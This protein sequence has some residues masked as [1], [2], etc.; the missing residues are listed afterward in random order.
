MKKGVV[1]LFFLTTVF[2]R[3]PAFAQCHFIPSTTSAVDTVVYTF[4][5]GNFA[6]YGCAPIDPTYWLSGNGMSVTCT[7]V[8]PQDYPAIR[9]WGMNDD[10]SAEV[11]VNSVS[12]FLDTTGSA[13]YAP[14][15][16][17]GISPGPDGIIFVNGK[18]VGANSNGL[19]NYSY[20]DVT[21][22]MTNVSVIQ[23]SGVNGAGWGFAGVVLDCEMGPVAGFTSA[24]TSVCPGTCIDFTIL[25]LNA[26]SFVWSFAGA[27]PAVSTDANPLSIC[28]NTPGS[29]D[30]TLIASNG[31][32]YDT[33][34]LINYITVYPFPPAQGILQSGD[35]LIA[36]AGAVSYQW[37]HDGNLISGATNYYYIASEGGN[38]N[39]VA[40][41]GNG[42]E[43]EA[44]I[45]D[46]I[47][48]SSQMAVSS[49]QWVIFPVPTADKL[50]IRGIEHSSWTG[51]IFFY[52]MTGKKVMA[53]L[54]SEN[55]NT[56]MIDVSNL[57]TGMYWLQIETKEKILRAKFLKR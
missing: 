41:D 34:T 50:Y 40:T 13:S 5:G 25:S 16:V 11:M 27:S 4:A 20:S 52:N 33:L 23:V 2:L 57:A 45:F 29:Y 28:Y 51:E 35:T 22:N 21:I 15:V 30:V 53:S 26:T 10:D 49:G 43:V 38:Y 3:N 42:C 46:V 44:A 56:I 9:V 39:V 55:Q 37:Y 31:N 24:P 7:F 19:G 36:N 1:L 48:A 54:I 17:C 47:A 18:I 6:S 8:T 14:K 12:Y 32:A